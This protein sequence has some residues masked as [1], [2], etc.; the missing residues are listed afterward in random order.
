[1]PQQVTVR[2]LDLV[3]GGLE[4]AVRQ[5]RCSRAEVIHVAIECRLEDFDDLAVDIDR[6]RD[7]SD[8]V[9]DWDQIRR[10]VINAEVGHADRS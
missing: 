4:T 2:L 3:A 9:L 1:M 5:L 10:A 6:L 7:S 8:L